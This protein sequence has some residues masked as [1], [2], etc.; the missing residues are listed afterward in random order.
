VTV[1]A[2]S[3]NGLFPIPAACPA[4]HLGAE[5]C[6]RWSYSYT[7]GG[8]VSV[9]AITVDSDLDIVAATSGQVTPTSNGSSGGM[10]VYAP[11]T[12]D[13]SLGQIGSGTLDLRTVKFASNAPVTGNVWTRA[14]VGI[15]TV[16]A[17][18]KVGNS[19]LSTC[20]IAGPD[21]IVSGISV[22]KAPIP[23]AQQDT[24]EGCDIVV[25]VDP[26]GCPT[27]VT[28]APAPGSNLPPGSCVVSQ[29]S[30][31][32]NGDTNQPFAGGVCG[33]KFVTGNNT[34]VWYCP[35]SF[36]SCFNVCK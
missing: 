7:A 19:G 11:G 29:T 33:S 2:Q 27:A 21:N 6:F 12:S 34:C 25:S 32:I 17:L 28:A 10:K 16:T 35:T 9:S 31:N 15:G 5:D 3:Q 1:T 8:T 30:F 18:A 4:N 14:N 36:G 22:G 23:A 13:S 20:A 24:F 26:K